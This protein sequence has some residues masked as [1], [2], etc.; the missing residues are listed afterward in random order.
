MAFIFITGCDSDYGTEIIG[1][2]KDKL[3]LGN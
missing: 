3:E 2:R 1:E